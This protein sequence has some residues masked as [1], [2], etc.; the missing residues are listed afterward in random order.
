MPIKK[1]KRHST[2]RRDAA[3]QVLQREERAWEMRQEFASERTIAK[4]LGVSQPAVSKMIKRVLARHQVALSM[5]VVEVQNTQLRMLSL[6][7][8]ETWNAWI[9][10]KS[11]RGSVQKRVREDKTPEP[12]QAA[13]A[14]ASSKALVKYGGR[15]FEET[16]LRTQ[17]EHGQ[18]AYLAV[19]LK[20][21]AD[22]RSI[23]G[24][25]SPRRLT[26]TDARTMLSQL[27]GTP[28]EQ[29]PLGPEDM[30]LETIHDQPI[31]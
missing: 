3:D 25:D 22:I 30:M 12:P 17:D 29:I 16:V 24:A 10:S 31:G 6:I 2:K 1:T 28:V 19:C 27:T 7:A 14:A 13:G 20:A 26:V 4:E 18:P 15:K 23:T 21:L 11:K 5:S 9:A 8:E